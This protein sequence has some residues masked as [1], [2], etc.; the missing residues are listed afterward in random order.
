MKISSLVLLLLIVHCCAAQLSKKTTSVKHKTG[1]DQKLAFGC[2]NW[3]QTPSQGSAAYV[4]KVGVPGNKITVEAT[5]YRTSFSSNGIVTDGDLVS[6]HTGP[7]DANYI[8]R[9][10]GAII[11]T[12]NGTLFATPP[13]CD[14]VLNKIYHFA[15]VYDGSTLK[16]Y[17]NGFLMTKVDASGNLYQNNLNTGIGLYDGNILQENFVGYINEVRIWNV[18][19][20][21][22]EIRANMNGSLPSPGTQPGLLAYYTFDDLINKQGNPAWNGTLAGA[23][24]INRQVPD[25]TFVPDSCELKVAVPCATIEDFNYKVDLCNPLAISFQSSA[26]AY[27]SIKW[28]LDDG[29]VISNSANPSHVFSSPGNHLV[30]MIV[31]EGGCADTVVKTI[32]LTNLP[33]NVLL[34][35]DTAICAGARAQLRTKPILGF[36]WKPTTYLDNPNSANPV[37]STPADITYYLNAEVPGKNLIVNGDFSQGNTGFSSEYNYANPNLTEG[38]YFVGPS[39][40]AW[41]VSLSACSGHT[42]GNDNMLLVNGAPVPG[43]NVW[44]QTVTVVPNTNYAF[45]TWVQALWPPNPAQLQFSINGK[46]TGT[47]ISASLPTCT[48]TQFYT[49]WNSGNNTTAVIS[50]VNINT[51]VQGNDFAL[52]D[53][54]FAPVLIQTDSVVIKVNSTQIKTSNDTTVCSGTTVQLNTTGSAATFAWTPSTGLSNVN[55]A[56]PSANPGVS[57]QYIVSGTGANGCKAKD[58]VQITVNP[59]PVIIKTNDTSICQNK[60]IQLNVGGGSAYNWKPSPD[61]SNPNI[62]NPVATPIS[63][64]VYYITVTNAASCSKSDSIKVSVNPNPIITKN[65]DTTICQSKTVQLNVTGGSKYIWQPATGLNNAAIFN[66]LASPQTSTV[67]YVSVTNSFNCS[68]ADSVKIFVKPSPVIVR[69]PDTTI[70]HDKT[71]QLNASGGGTYS[72]SPSIGLSNNAVNNPVASPA[73]STTYYLTVTGNNNCSSSDSIKLSV[74]PAPVFTINGGINACTGVPV[75]LS[76]AGGD[77][78][79]WDPVAG[80]N[81]TTVPNP[82][83][84][85]LVSTVYTVKIKSNVCSDSA[86]LSVPVTVLPLP[87]VKASSSNNVDCSKPASQLLASGALKYVWTP[88]TGL[89]DST[90]A[91]PLSSPSASTL[92]IVK[93]TDLNGCSNSDSVQ[94]VVS[95]AGDLLVNMPNAFSPNGD[96]K[97]DC[98]GISRFAGLLQNVQL[99]VYDRFGVR[100]FYTSNP[101]NCWDGRYK[102]K[103]QDSGGF[104]YILKAKTFCGDIFKKGIIMLLK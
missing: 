82:F 46:I 12:T 37:S 29:T 86:S 22:A 78:Y 2:N 72:W 73:A 33:A 51:A 32:S 64:T 18:A 89:N 35:P 91:A 55:I 53:I 21:Q 8:L 25:C 23:A 71:I 76:A 14:I 101:A 50:I 15:M 6:K 52:D 31:D 1:A 67:Y 83:A 49:T 30:N 54:S 34:T 96:G 11:T 102:G 94:I 5:I 63:N 99:S 80:L 85:P 39:P 44:K 69:T 36:C 16:F 93:G 90:I 26:T 60:T 75:Q 47:L 13:V 10:T 57:T 56:N 88:S 74:S 20:T 103:L 3:L 70:C 68:S 65:N 45:S 41:N 66:P 4:G 62:P 77:S 92:Y 95:H 40:N 58:T 61:L 59:S 28:E 17:R 27:N 38:Q 24:S 98:F 104:V 19:R 84:T 43:V 81:K 9:P 48:W 100:V 87:L 97:N 42:N 7:N 79:S